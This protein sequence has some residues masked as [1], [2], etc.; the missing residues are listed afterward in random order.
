MK[1]ACERGITSNGRVE[2]LNLRQN[3]RMIAICEFLGLFRRWKTRALR[4]ASKMERK[5]RLNVEL[6]QTGKK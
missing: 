2:S 3:R 6:S 4:F 1:R 5:E